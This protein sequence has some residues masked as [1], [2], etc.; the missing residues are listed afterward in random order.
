ME[1][2]C[3]LHLEYLSLTLKKGP[4]NLLTDMVSP[5]KNFREIKFEVVLLVLE[6]RLLEVKVVLLLLLVL[7]S[8][9]DGRVW[10][11]VF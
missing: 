9:C 1:L 5:V 10:T 2:C 11:E 7:E 3:C 6:F 8:R 4:F